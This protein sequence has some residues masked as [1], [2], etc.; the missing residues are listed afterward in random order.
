MRLWQSGSDSSVDQGLIQYH[1][2]GS[3]AVALWGFCVLCLL[4]P[5]RW[6]RKCVERRRLRCTRRTAPSMEWTQIWQHWQ[7][8]V[9]I[10]ADW[11]HSY[12]CPTPPDLFYTAS[13]QEGAP[14]RADVQISHFFYKSCNFLSTTA[15]KFRSCCNSYMQEILN[16]TA[17]CFSYQSWF[18]L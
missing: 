9:M 12:T 13:E 5:C 3:Q 14:M 15:T 11:L 17:G 18:T 10:E 16:R 4:K 8:K 1:T 6:D 7:D 2:F